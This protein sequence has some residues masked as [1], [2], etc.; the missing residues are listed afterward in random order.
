M[1]K[2]GALTMSTEERKRLSVMIRRKEQ[3][4]T[5]REVAEILRISYRQARRIWKRYLNGGDAGLVH[6]NR[7]RKS[8]RH[9][10]S[11]VREQIIELYRQ[12]YA[13]FG[14]T[15]ASEKLMNEDDLHVDHETLR[16][17]LIENGLWSKKRERRQHR[18]RRERKQHFGEMIQMDGSHHEWFEKRGQKCCLMSMVDDATGITMALMS[19]EE[20][21]EAAMQILLSWINKYG[22]PVSLYTDQK[23]VYVPDDKTKEAALEEGKM[24]Y[25][26]FG[27][28]CKKLGIKIIAARSP[29]AK[30]RVERKHAVFQDR[31]V[32][33]LRLK[34]I[35]EIDKA[36]ELL[37]DFVCELNKKFMVT[38]AESTNYHHPA[39]NKERLRDIF[40]WED[41]RT[42]ANDWT[43]R[44][45]NRIFQVVRQSNMPSP[46]SIITVRKR[47]DGSLQFLHEH[48]EIACIE[49]KAR[50]AKARPTSTK[51]RKQW[52]PGPEHPWNQGLKKKQRMGTLPPNPQSLPFYG[53]P[54]GQVIIR[55]GRGDTPRP[56]VQSPAPALGSLSSVA[57]LS[58]QAV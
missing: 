6:R 11:K 36:N 57:L 8:N 17:W 24:A 55:K 2:K 50:E 13:D 23:N 5:L 34:E 9:F 39:E 19:G 22:E 37:P 32:K 16:L 14:P 20:T 4:I 44:Y 45:E 38:P 3:G 27:L 15:L 28:A 49:I 31:W 40:C 46:K 26:A 35:S 43:L 1:T 56:S 29:Q 25:T 47:L 18:Q 33:E 30:G 21:T 58:E 7:G 41:T 51:P 42:L 10:S 12:R 52:R 48:E 53:L 54:D